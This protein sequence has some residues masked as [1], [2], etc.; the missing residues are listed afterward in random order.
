VEQTTSAVFPQ[1]YLDR[2]VTLNE[3]RTGEIR[4]NI[5]AGIERLGS[6][7]TPSGGF[8][9]WPGQG[10]SHDWGTSYAG[11]FLVEARRAGYAVPQA[12]LDKWAAYQKNRA[13][14]WSGRESA[15]DQ[16]YRLYTLALA[17]QP[18]L[19][20]MNR[21]REEPDLENAGAWRLAAAY[22]YAGQRDAARSLVRALSLAVPKYREL[23]GT[24]GTELRDKAMI[25]ETLTI[26]GETARAAS[27]LEGISAALSSDSWLSTQ[28]TAYALIAVIPYVAGAAGNDTV[29]VEYGMGS[30]LETASFS[31]PVSRYQLRV[32]MGSDSAFQVRNRSDVPLYARIIVR[33][34]P[35]EGSEPALSQGLSLQAEYFS[36]NGAR[37]DPDA[38]AVGD[39]MVV[40]V[41][42][43]N[44]GDRDLSEIALVHALPAS[45]EI[46]NTRLADGRSQDNSRFNYQ[47]IR[48]DRVMSYFD[49]RRGASITVSFQVNRAYG[50]NYF[51]P[52]VHA[53]AMYDESIR[54]LIPGTRPPR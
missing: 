22:W 2:V 19:G 18:E 7:Q 52:A 37:V 36:P 46:V 29:T 5:A 41:S 24:F 15:R 13:A 10:E 50:G 42:V 20:A 49:L 27:L 30:R 45:W 4:T 43:R 28:E 32:P 16:A 9:Y 54:A 12:L 51:R 21:L 39:D 47:D 14:S 31:S 6:F 26:M 25:L 38:L 34:L 3:A 35:E 40:R 11:H 23:S 53:Y 17:G 1:L 33:G 48:D 8:S 44:P